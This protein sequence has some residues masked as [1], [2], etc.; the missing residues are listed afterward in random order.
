[1]SMLD[2]DE[3]LQ[4]QDLTRLKSGKAV[5]AASGCMV[6]CIRHNMRNTAT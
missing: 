2:V 6:L 3:A 4:T 1:M 5:T